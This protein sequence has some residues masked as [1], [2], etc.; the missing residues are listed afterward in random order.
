MPSVS[1]PAFQTSLWS[2]APSRSGAVEHAVRTLSTAPDA[3]RGA[4]H[5]RPEVAA[6]VLDVAGYVASR[7]LHRLRLLEP[8]FG[9]GVF[10]R[11]AARRLLQ[12][13]TAAGRAGGALALHDAIRGVEVHRASLDRVRADLLELLVAHGVPSRGAHDV[14][15]AWLVCDDFLLRPFEHGFNTVVG[16]PPYVRIESIPS[17]LIER[18]RKDYASVYDRADLYVPFIERGLQLL[19]EG[20][21]LSFICADRWMKN[22]YGGPLREIVS[23][24]YHLRNVVR[25]HG[26]DAFE[27]EVDAYPS[28]FTLEQSSPEPRATRVVEPPALG[29]DTLAVLAQAIEAAEPA[30]GVQVLEGVVSGSEPWL[31]SDPGVLRVLRALEADHPTL[32]DAGCRVG[33]GVATGADRVFIAPADELPIEPDRVLPLAMARDANPDGTLDWSGLALANPFDDQGSLVDLDAYPRLRAYFEAHGEVLRGR[34]VARKSPQRWY[35]TIDKVTAS[36][37][38]RPKL[39]VPDIKGSAVVALDEGGL[40]PHHNLYVVTSDE[41]DIH[42]L[43]AV[44]RSRIAEFQVAT[45]AVR[46]RGGYLRF[47]AQYL[48]RIRL[49]RWDQV[50]DSLRTRLAQ[51]GQGPREACDA[52]AVELYDL[53]EAD[54]TVVRSETR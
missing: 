32:A 53:S 31:L 21:R 29:S 50:P 5:T 52:A 41:W 54:W 34:H 28:V 12:A 1:E 38:S 17:A 18:Y 49:P 44:L 11:E 43:Q 22:R 4:V 45:Y 3:D 9:T 23:R 6:F 42:A 15:D 20:G 26:A 27:S 40:Y 36:L 25:L 33:I 8:S 37:V 2:S 35:R 16:N 10:L 7:P 39:L 48:R 47:Q 51:A 13:W 19:R 46:M 14:L 24:G 30:D